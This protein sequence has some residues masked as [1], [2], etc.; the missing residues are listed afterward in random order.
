MITMKGQGAAVFAYGGKSYAA[1]NGLLVCPEQLEG[2]AIRHGFR[3][4]SP[5]ELI[6]LA[7]ARA[8][9][10]DEPE[11]EAGHTDPV[12]VGKEVDPLISQPVTA[13]ANL[14]EDHPQV[15][16][17]AALDVKADAQVAAAAAESDSETAG[18]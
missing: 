17:T 5:A 2:Q 15:A 7:N 14:P 13:E 8:A 16:A 11:P 12:A 6:E 9:V 3:K 10:V 18:A 1:V 4:L